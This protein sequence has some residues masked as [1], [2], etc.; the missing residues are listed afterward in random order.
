MIRFAAFLPV[1]LLMGCAEYAKGRFPSLQ[2]RPIESRS[3]AE[4]AVEVP[5]VAPDSG[6]DAKAADAKTKIAA[7]HA[8]FATAAA[9]ATSAAAAAKGDSV[10]GDRWIAAQSALADL[11]VYRADSSTLVTDLQE[12]SLER[13]ANGQPPYPALEDAVT[14][15]Q[16]ELDAE[17]AAIGTLSARLP[18]D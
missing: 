8:A 18:Q 11:D 4:P 16:A 14:A 7:T 5:V 10:G 13:A 9:K 1:L 2:P 3:D 17:T 12:A 15:A 6:L